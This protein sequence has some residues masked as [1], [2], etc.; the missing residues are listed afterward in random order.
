MSMMPSEVAQLCK[1]YTGRVSIRKERVNQGGY[2]KGGIYFGTG[3]PLY[4]AQDEDGLWSVYF[5]ATDRNEAI[6]IMRKRY[7]IAQIKRSR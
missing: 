7:P 6:A 1:E 4:F 2:I 5:R 3:K